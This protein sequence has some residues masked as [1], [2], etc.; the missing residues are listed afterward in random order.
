MKYAPAVAIGRI[1]RFAARVRKPGGGSAIPGVVVNAIAPSYLT[2]TLA[3]FPNGLVIVSGSAGKSTTTKM[4][5]AVLRSHGL[6][7][8]TNP[9]TANIAQGLT[10]ALLEASNWRGIVPGDIAVL[11]MDEGHAAK[12]A[13]QLRAKVVV[14]TNVMVDQI[15]RFFD[16][17]MVAGMLA[18]IAGRA[19]QA[20][21]SNAD[22]AMLEH[23]VAKLPVPVDRFGVSEQVLAAAPRGLGYSR[24][25]VRRLAPSAPNAVVVQSVNRLTAT[26]SLAGEAVEVRLPARGTH[27]ATDA[28][29]ALAAARRVLAERWSTDIATSAVGAVPPVFARGERTRVREQLVDFVLVQNPASF[30]LNVDAIA[31]EADC[32]MF[33]IGTDVRDPSYFWPVD[34]AALGR[35]AVV[36]GAKPEEAALMLAYDGVEI[37]TVEP[38]L[39]AAIEQF[40]ALPTPPS[41]VKTIVFTAD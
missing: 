23:I 36:S 2:D 27:Y 22:D 30:Q 3:T 14:L 34:T 21:I 8:F 11:E 39:E 1:V 13:P 31:G 33:A 19:E 5:V 41:G 25:A 17:E 10:S 29:A 6:K 40:L 12:L 16:S 38:V 15:D 24:T 20:V 4:L 7:V 32:V 28:A 26:L 9:S 18:V 35:V 37:D